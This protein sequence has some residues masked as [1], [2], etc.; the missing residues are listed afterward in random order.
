LLSM[1][2]GQHPFFVNWFLVNWVVNWFVEFFC[3]FQIFEANTSCQCSR[4]HL[5][6]PFLARSVRFLPTSWRNRPC[7]RVD[8][9]GVY[10]GIH[11]HVL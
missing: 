2:D 4:K 10:K 1:V 8:L 6:Q 9:Y 3:P 5:V 11:I 7:M